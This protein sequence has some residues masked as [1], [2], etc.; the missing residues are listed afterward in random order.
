MIGD[1]KPV[2]LDEMIARLPPERQA[3]V[4]RRA[5]AL[6]AEQREAVLRATR[7]ILKPFEG[8]PNTAATRKVIADALARLVQPIS[9]W[10]HIELKLEADAE[11]KAMIFRLT[12]KT[13]LG[14]NIIRRMRGE[15]PEGEA[16][17]ALL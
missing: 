3:E 1:R 2:S 17:G 16:D 8:K 14:A 15:A 11:K 4:E 9:L 10:D 6:I 13:A 12:A 5:A 7:E